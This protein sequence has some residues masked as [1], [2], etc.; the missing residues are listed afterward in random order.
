MHTL[1]R[2][3]VYN[4]QHV[5]P[6]WPEAGLSPTTTHMISPT[7]LLTLSETGIYQL[8][9]EDV[10]ALG[11]G[12]LNPHTLCL[13][14]GARE[15]AGEWQGDDDTIFEAGEALFFY[16][17][18]RFS[19]W[20]RADAIRLVDGHRPGLRMETRRAPPGGLEQGHPWLTR[21][22]EQNRLYTPD[23]FLGKAI[24]AGRDGERWIWDDLTRA[25]GGTGHISETYPFALSNIAATHG[26]T[27]TL[28]LIGYTD[29]ASKSGG[30]P[31]HRVELDINGA[32]LG[33]A[34]WHG[35]RAV[36]V[37]QAIPGGVLQPGHNILTLRLV[38]SPG[39]DL[40][41]IW[42]DAFAISYR[43][44]ASAPT[45]VVHVT[46]QGSAY[47][48]TLA[49]SDADTVRVYDVTHPSMP[50]RL[51][52]IQ[53]DGDTATL[54]DTGGTPAHYSLASADGVLRPA[55]VRSPEDV[56]RLDPGPHTGADVIFITPPAFADTLR[57][58][59][60][61]R[62]SRGLSSVMVNVLGIYDHWG[63]GRPDPQ[64]IHAFLVDAY[65]TWHPRPTYVVLVGD[66]SFDPKGYRHSPSHNVIPPYLAN[67]DPWAGETS[68]DNRYACVD[69][70][71]P[72][73][74][75]LIGRLPAQSPEEIQAM[76]AKIIA[77]ER[78]PAPGGWNANVALVADDADASGD[79][80]ASSEATVP[81][82]TLPFTA[83]RHYC[84]GSDPQLSDC[85]MQETEALR[86]ALLSRWQRGAL[87]TQFF[88]H[89]S[90]HQWGAERFF[91]LEDV[92]YLHNHLRL[93]VVVAMTCF[94]GAFH[95][96]EPTL[97][98]TLVK[99]T[100][101]AIAAW[102]PTGL[103]VNTGHECL[104]QGFFPA[105][106]SDTVAT[107]GEAAFQGKLA[108]AAS[109]MYQDLLDTFGLL[110]DPALRINREVLPWAHQI[111]LP[112]VMW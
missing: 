1:I 37:T 59:V 91:H 2:S 30:Q 32:P 14:Q 103:G 78:A 85:S 65:A 15:I 100:G 77:Y 10:R 63:D 67:V 83:T 41:G 13:F 9:Y 71:D 42:L 94:T 86:R 17:E 54:G 102:G 50:H 108:L 38:E 47:A 64:A 21:V 58:L 112:V 90:W 22:F 101:G 48:Y 49:I 56:W 105:V 109:G 60:T 26:A 82:L 23:R 52:A 4:P 95:R 74:D 93:P 35:R 27:V 79:F 97:D 81:Y 92:A 57:S 16:A 69:G 72:L 43:Y 46:G 87:V 7:A 24:P 36:T 44:A 3:Q 70:D 80:P 45:Q 29:A 20:T 55:Q 19:R 104:A 61:W 99:A 18:P 76:V 66:G 75:L 111:W 33:E 107:V 11:L 25:W 40:D 106:F 68:A 8:T 51:T 5:V 28:W 31:D 96:P 98:E 53:V 6:R 73:P 110:G 89:A 34:Q 12:T 84:A 39:V 62:E 88:G